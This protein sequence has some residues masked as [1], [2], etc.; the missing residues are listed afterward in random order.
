MP[1]RLAHEE[2][3]EAPRTNILRKSG[4]YEHDGLAG[5][6]FGAPNCTGFAMVTQCMGWKAA[7]STLTTPSVI[8][9]LVPTNPDAIGKGYQLPSTTCAANS[10]YPTWLKGVVVLQWNGTSIT[11]NAGLVSKP[12]GM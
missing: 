4:L 8:S 9:D 3:N 7:T 10:D 1:L 12:C 2:S 5:E 6:P 11:E